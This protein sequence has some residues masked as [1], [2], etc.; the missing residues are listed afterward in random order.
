MKVSKCVFSII[1]TLFIF[2]ACKHGMGEHVDVLPPEL[3]ITYPSP[4]D[5]I[6][7]RDS[8]LLKG[9]VKDDIALQNVSVTLD[10]K[11][12][13]AYH[14]GPF[15]ANLD[16]EN[17]TWSIWLNN[18]NPD[19]SYPIKDATY[20]VT[21]V[22]TDKTGRKN[23]ETAEY[24]IDNTAPVVVMKQPGSADPAIPENYGAELRI[25]GD[26]VDTNIKEITF[27]AYDENQENPKSITIPLD[28]QAIKSDI[29]VFGD[30]DGF[31]NEIYGDV[32][33][34]TKKF[35]YTVQA[36]DTAKLYK[37]D[38]IVETG[39]I[40]SVYYLNNETMTTVSADELYSINN[41]SY[42]TNND[43][44]INDIKKAEADKIVTKLT[45]NIFEKNYTPTIYVEES[46]VLRRLGVF[47]LYPST[48]PTYTVDIGSPVTVVPFDN[49]NRIH[50]SSKIN[51]VL[52][53]NKDGVAIKPETV[54]IRALK[55]KSDFSGDLNAIFN[56][57][58]YADIFEKEYRLFPPSKTNY[59][60]PTLENGKY[61]FKLEQKG[62]ENPTISRPDPLNSTPSTT[63]T[64]VDLD[65]GSYIIEVTGIDESNPSLIEGELVG[66]FDNGSLY[67]G[68]QRT[69]NNEPPVFGE[70]K[71][72]G[73]VPLSSSV[74]V[75]GDVT[76]AG[77]VTT[78]F[79]SN[80]HTLQNIVYT[81]KDSNNVTLVKEILLPDSLTRVNNKTYNWNFTLSDKNFGSPPPSLSTTYSLEIM[82]KDITENIKTMRY[83]VY[84]DVEK[85]EI[86]NLTHSV[87]KINTDRRITV[88]GNASD[89]DR[90]ASG[91]YIATTKNSSNTIV[92]TPIEGTFDNLSNFTIP[93][94][95]GTIADTNTLEIAVTVKDRV[96]LDT[97]EKFIFDSLKPTISVADSTI[98][99]PTWTD[100]SDNWYNTGE[101]T[102][103]LAVRDIA[104]IITNVSGIKTVEWSS[105]NGVSWNYM[106]SGDSIYW[107]SATLFTESGSY[108]I[109][110][111]V[112]DNS[113]N[114]TI[115]PIMFT[116]KVDISDPSE[117][118]LDK[119]DGKSV[120]DYPTKFS[121]AK[122]DITV[123]FKDIYD[124]IGG[125]GI[126]SVQLVKI[127]GQDFTVDNQLENVT[128]N[129]A[130]V[131]ITKKQLEESSVGGAVVFRVFD[132]VGNFKD[133]TLFTLSIDSLAPSISITSHATN[134]IVNKTIFVEGTA[135]DTN[136]IEQI[137]LC[138]KNGSNW[139]LVSEI[140]ENKTRWSFNLD[141]TSYTDGSD[142]TIRASAID[143][144]G[145]EGHS[146]EITVK[147][148]QSSDIPI[149][150]VRDLDLTPMK[151]AD[152][153]DTV[154]LKSSGATAIIKGSIL[155]DDGT[156]SAD[157]FKMYVDSVL[158]DSSMLKYKMG[159]WELDLGAIDGE[160]IIT[161]AVTD[162]ENTV[163]DSGDGSVNEIISVTDGINK[164][165]NI[166][167]TVDTTEPIIADVFIDIT[168]AKGL[169]SD[170]F[171]DITKTKITDNQFI[172]G[173]SAE[174]VLEFD[175]TD[176]NGVDFIK[177]YNN[178]IYI[179][180][181]ECIDS[182]TSTYVAKID[183]KDTLLFADQNGFTTINIIAEDKAGGESTKE[184]P[185]FIDNVA[186]TMDILSPVHL[187]QV[188]G[189][190]AITGTA[191]N[192]GS[193]AS[194]P[195]TD[196]VMFQIPHKKAVGN[197]WELDD[198]AWNTV[199]AGTTS[200]KILFDGGLSDNGKPLLKTYITDHGIET[201]NETNLWY[202][203]IVFKVQDSLGN[204]LTTATDEYKV[205]LDPDGDKP[206]VEIISPVPE[207]GETKV[208]LGG[209]V[210]IFGS[211]E[212]NESVD[213]VWMQIDVDGDENYNDDDKD[214]LSSKGYIIDE[215]HTW[216]GIKTTG[217]NSW[218]FTINSNGEFNP[219]ND[220]EI[221]DI[222]FRVRSKDVDGDVSPWSESIHLG[223]DRTAPRIGSSN[224]LKLVQYESGNSGTIIAEKMYEPDMWVTGE[225]Y[226]TGSIEDEGDI[227][228]ITV[229]DKTGATIHIA[230]ASTAW[231]SDTVFGEND[232]YTMNMPLGNSRG[233]FVY[234]I[235]A[236][237]NTTPN[238]RETT[239][240]ISIQINNKKPDVEAVLLGNN[241]SIDDINTVQQSNG[242]FTLGSTVIETGG[243]LDKVL[244][245][246]ERPA[247]GIEGNRIYNVMEDTNNVTNIVDT[248][249][250]IPCLHLEDVTRDAEDTL[251]HTSINGNK[252]VR[253]G[254]IVRI[255]GV[256]RFITD[257]NGSE[258]TFTP[259]VATSYKNADIAYA[260][261]VNNRKI[262]SVGANV[263]DAPINDDG[264]LMVESVEGTN[265][266][267]DWFASIDSRNITDGPI[268]IKYLAYDESGLA[269]DIK[270]VVT[271]IDNN[272]PQIAKVWLGTDLNASGNIEDYEK[273]EYS[274]LNSNGAATSDATV[275]ASGENGSTRFTAKGTTHIIPEVVGGNGDLYYSLETS[276]HSGISVSDST[277]IRTGDGGST[278][279]K[280]TEI[281]LVDE[282]NDKLLGLE[283]TIG[284]ARDFTIKIWDSTAETTIG[285]DSQHANISLSMHIDSVDEVV[286]TTTIND[287]DWDSETVNSLY[288]NSRENGHIELVTSGNDK[289]SGKIT[290]D[291]TASD[292]KVIKEFWAKID[293][294][295]NSFVKIAEYNAGTWTYTNATAIAT[296]WYFEVNT[297][298]ETF[299]Q[300][301]HSVDWKLHWDSEKLTGVAGL[302]KTIT[303][304]AKDAKGNYTQTGNTY[305]V[306]VVPYIT[307]V[308]TAL[309][310]Y[311][312]GGKPTAS[313]TA[314]GKYPVYL[315]EK[316]ITVKG[317]N[318]GTNT[319]VTVPSTSGEISVTVNGV[320]S[321]NNTNNKSKAYNIR[322][323]AN[324]TLDDDVYFDVWTTKALVAEGNNPGR[325]YSPE[326]RIKSDGTMG[327]AYTTDNDYYYMPG[328]DTKGENY[329]NH[330]L[331]EMG[332][333]PFYE[334]AF[335]FDSE[336]NSYGLST[337]IDT[338]SGGYSAYTTFYFDQLSSNA[339]ERSSS[340]I[341]G[342]YRRRLMCTTVK[343]SGASDNRAKSP[344]IATTNHSS[345][346]SNTNPTGVYIAYYD[347]LMKEIRYHWG[348]VGDTHEF[349]MKLINN[350]TLESS[351]NHGF[352][353][354]D[355]V[356]LQ[357]KGANNTYNPA[358]NNRYFVKK[359]EDNKIQLCTTKENALKEN[360]SV[361][362]LS[363]WETSDF[364]VSS[365]GGQI[366]DIAAGYCSTNNPTSDKPSDTSTANYSVLSDTNTGAY[367]SLDACAGI[368]TSTDNNPLGD[369]V[370][371]TFTEN[372]QL[373]YAYNT[374]PRS[375]TNTVGGGWTIQTVDTTSSIYSAVKID[376]EGGI[377]IAYSDDAENLNYM[378]LSQY[379][380]SFTTNDTPVIVDSFDSVGTHLRLDVAKK[381]A[382]GSYI[383]YISYYS[384]TQSRAKLAYRVSN[385]VANGTDNDIYTGK[386]EVTHIPSANSPTE[387]SINVGVHRIAEGVQTP[388]TGAYANGSS[389]PAVAYSL[390]NKNGI[391]IAQK[392]GGN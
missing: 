84:Y 195:M 317:F 68:F 132:T 337:N 242:F 281:V 13:I 387:D 159:T 199:S 192:G 119:I 178:D 305:T 125:S 33:S 231:F 9:N 297:T 210:R 152:S 186:P 340:H 203:P 227:S 12:A 155:D 48:H 88:R 54:T 386:W 313:R 350:T 39:N 374:N 349:G 249:N 105:D 15:D 261:V 189:T 170:W 63:G 44:S 301:G 56:E 7:I 2:T 296:G 101:L 266:R 46:T 185:V 364:K 188:T 265:G 312:Q 230:N 327:F 174:F 255:G 11:G 80:D 346:R 294:F 378:Y 222:Q 140:N 243:G 390:S 177:V 107:N 251:S 180:D 295:K 128:N 336:G 6:I 356:T 279:S 100:L 291:G 358:Y 61:T 311:D 252:N 254:G 264:D 58:G 112:T 161:F 276:G 196:A 248:I 99:N 145:N 353:N 146:E 372:G 24:T 156:I 45:S 267:Y 223:I 371:M 129:T 389:N 298:T 47:E 90:L 259:S 190:I 268:H 75:T 108:P 345:G 307:S 214:Y 286:P 168:P 76:V 181:A 78:G 320:E 293:G 22:A 361:V 220:G 28:S 131:T 43:T 258:I 23:T 198:S 382:S 239:R 70:T 127:G 335:A 391:E 303:L 323:I 142:I 153:T 141:T 73:T 215:T 104:P 115:S 167:L 331:I 250:G 287:L 113:L 81:L 62:V 308:K 362:N 137:T 171:D 377:H 290:F 176:A 324:N 233:S 385:T 245:W 319:S 151:T 103:K 384:T 278:S 263:G 194:L 34:D 341:G 157:N 134:D 191:S 160:R 96:G 343:G 94:D 237:D 197:G 65:Y 120:T 280:T 111:R 164:L 97:T 217:T 8:F 179:C 77:S 4:F 41:S 162:E 193:G 64:F 347:D 182:A 53:P 370:V 284:T 292:D 260:M 373:K 154:W 271:K 315:G 355:E 21:I 36:S 310:N 381:D 27:T 87:T 114:E 133:F 300:D 165:K 37:G 354:G 95:I 201:S 253:V 240:E 211:A 89:D 270:T 206:K 42:Y 224:P 366:K 272:R 19:G 359:G 139:D 200:W 92:G 352:F 60:I 26:A 241:A 102:L 229:T 289:V 98:S 379:N 330:R 332:Y 16:I 221:E 299:G 283:D 79:S 50:E 10:A 124:N 244:F 69:S 383:P 277:K 143:F 273:Q 30:E 183:A 93:I 376:G 257:V 304:Y 14:Y 342:T 219:A 163:F 329:K 368:V 118:G 322:N 35:Y 138:V 357:K 213:S 122:K 20:T 204:T 314:L 207:A 238:P 360:G 55:L 158:Q 321:I 187:E 334:S 147:I 123:T 74:Q 135:F 316:G 85:P 32:F 288:G 275:D 216:W 348:T 91:S 392:L 369:I 117:I 67:Y 169:A 59:A 247:Y 130:T 71:I 306:D 218:N 18:K 126:K 338:S 232:G 109:I 339:L 86:T 51:I 166:V 5:T 274:T 388:I 150:T 228:E 17:S 246:F 285:T 235:K 40:S 365:V 144:G 212:D 57:T 380:E 29:G 309:S 172:G 326:L 184:L 175:V 148:Q 202:I 208:V 121:N 110:F 375:D 66:D 136:K 363:G 282:A 234:T 269:S 209:I 38:S 367:V 83:S 328:K 149:I 333:A 72:M 106:T 226:L 82:A 116:P 302:G 1:I 49:N 325:Y 205:I 344:V 173:D 262:E 25:T 256:D 236:L 52:S 225:W 318:L 351:T 31:Y 3:S